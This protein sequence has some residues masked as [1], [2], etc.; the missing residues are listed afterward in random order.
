[1]RVLASKGAGCGGR[2]IHHA[3]PAT[4]NSP[5]AG[6][7]VA[8]GMATRARLVART[9]WPTG[10]S[11]PGVRR[12]RGEVRG[13]TFHWAPAMDTPRLS[14]GTRGTRGLPI[15]GAAAPATAVREVRATG[16]PVRAPRMG[17]ASPTTNP[18]A[19]SRTDG[20]LPQLPQRGA[21]AEP[22]VAALPM[23]ALHTTV[24]VQRHLDRIAGE[25]RAET[26]VRELLGQAVQRLHKLCSNLLHRRYPRLARPPLNL[27]VEE[28]LS[29]VVARLI[30]A[31][32][33]V[34][35]GNVRQFF[36]LANQHMRWELNHLA[37]RLD[38]Q[39]HAEQGLEHTLCAPASNGSEL[40]VDARRML[41]VIDSLPVD[42]REVFSLVRIQGLSHA[43]AAEVLGVC[44]KTVQRRIHRSTLFLARTLGDLRP[45][46]PE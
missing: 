1:M 2:C 29:A 10:A 24:L 7:S 6:T 37:R 18:G 43:E 19:S 15:P 3:T 44:T 36:A 46:G 40:S 14:S 22:P 35:P 45:T 34:R 38:E 25:T 4:H 9:A 20:S 26:V 30:R 11:G 23:R 21:V 27:Q 41:A 17:V 32:R 31:L 28:L 8:I 5:A 33:A 13:D 12:A 39:P 42:E 16:C